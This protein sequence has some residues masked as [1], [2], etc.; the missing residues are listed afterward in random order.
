VSG[1]AKRERAVIRSLS[2]EWTVVDVGHE[3]VVI[4]Y[5]PSV[6]HGLSLILTICI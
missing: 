1:A 5:D 3:G 2:I 4:C 6:L